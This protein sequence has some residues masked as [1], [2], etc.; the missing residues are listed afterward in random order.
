MNDKGIFLIL[1]AVYGALYLTELGCRAFL[2]LPE[3]V[4]KARP[5]IE[6]IL[7]HEPKYHLLFIY[8]GGILFCILYAVG[9][10][11]LLLFWKL[12]PWIFLSSLI[13]DTLYY[14]KKIWLISTGWEAA[15]YRWRCVF[16][17]IVLAAIFFG[18][19]TNLFF[20]Q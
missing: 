3:R 11:G 1:M 12:A 8:W 14:S 6:E 4:Q 13:L 10:I 9:F 20:K 16:S 7:R 5:N 2:K 15:V 18:A 17:G 19:A